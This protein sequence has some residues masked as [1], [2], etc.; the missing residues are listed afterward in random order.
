[1]A[2]VKNSARGNPPVV[3]GGS[4]TVDPCVA[5]RCFSRARYTCSKAVRDRRA[6]VFV[7]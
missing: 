2:D 6:E 3:G 5:M 1:M 4:G 7:A